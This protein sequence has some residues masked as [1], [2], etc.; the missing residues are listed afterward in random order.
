[1][2]FKVIFYRVY[3]WNEG[4][5]SGMQM[6]IL[7]TIWKQ[8]SKKKYCFSV[9]TPKGGANIFAVMGIVVWSSYYFAFLNL[10]LP[11]RETWKIWCSKFLSFK[12]NR[13]WMTDWMDEWMN[14]WITVSHVIR[15]IVVIC[16]LNITFFTAVWQTAKSG[17]FLSMLWGQ[18]GAKSHDCTIIKIYNNIRKTSKPCALWRPA[19]LRAGLF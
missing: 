3:V 16:L 5:E 8:T 10:F 1:M 17:E 19:L 2:D 14:E 4:R 18:I 15:R 12:L 6:V 7:I 9:L 13:K 11:K